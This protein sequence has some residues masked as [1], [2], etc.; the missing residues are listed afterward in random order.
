MVDL[1]LFH[2]N[3][4]GN[5]GPKDRLNRRTGRVACFLLEWTGWYNQALSQRLLGHYR[6]F[7]L[8]KKDPDHAFIH[9]EMSLERAYI[10]QYRGGHA[11]KYALSRIISIIYRTFTLGRPY[12]AVEIE[13]FNGTLI[14]EHADVLQAFLHDAEND[15]TAAFLTAM[16]RVN[17]ILGREAN[18]PERDRPVL[19]MQVNNEYH[20]NTEYKV[21]QRYETHHNNY[22]QPDIPSKEAAKGKEKNVLSK[23]QVLILFDL[24]SQVAKLEKIDY[25]KPNRF[26]GIAVFLH[27]VT[28]KAKNSWMDELSKYKTR[29]LYAFHTKGELSQLISD[30]INIADFL[31]GAGYYGLVKL[32]DNKIRELERHKKE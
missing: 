20:S 24:L 21:Y 5:Y 4:G 14:R 26:E 23:K 10:L 18:D 2:L 22:I 31:R 28:G 6:L 7:Q 29:D 27:A 8:Y 3:P 9:R 25:S 19:L 11:M 15:F 16:K 32:A 17:A 1:T 12:P 13:G 30:V